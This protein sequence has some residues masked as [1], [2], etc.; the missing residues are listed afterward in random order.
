MSQLEA[1]RDPTASCIVYRTYAAI[2]DWLTPV[3]STDQASGIETCIASALFETLHQALYL[4]S[5]IAYNIAIC[6]PSGI[7]SGIVTCIASG[8]ESVNQLFT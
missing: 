2:L 1:L 4:A 6:I 7:V 8:N 5:G 3:T